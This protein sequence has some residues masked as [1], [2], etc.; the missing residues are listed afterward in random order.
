LAIA[1]A[2]I[3][4]LRRSFPM[5]AIPKLNVPRLSVAE[6]VAGFD[7]RCAL[8]LETTA[9]G[10]RVTGPEISGA[11]GDI[12]GNRAIANLALGRFRAESN[13]RL[14]TTA[15]WFDHPHP[16]DR[17]HKGE[18]DFAAMKLAR[19]YWLFRGGDGLEESTQDRIRRFFLTTEFMSHYHSE[20]HDLLFHTSRYLMAKSFWRET[21]EGYGK[22]GAEI[23]RE[24]ADWLL[25]FIR[26]RAQRGWAEFDSSCYFA[27]DWEC[28]CGLYDFCGS[29]GDLPA[30][31]PGEDGERDRELHLLAGM[32]MNLLLADM[33]VDSLN[34]LYGGAHGRIYEPHALDHTTASTYALQL[35]YFGCVDPGSLGGR[36]TLVDAVTSPFRP[37]ELVLEIAL[38]RPEVYE[39]RER[40][41][42]HSTED[43]RPVKPIPGSIR[44]YTYYTPEF[45]MGAVQRQDP[46]PEDSKA[47]WYAHHEQHEWDLSIGTRVAARIFTHHPGS[48]GPEHGY[49]TG[50]LRCCC[51]H[52]FQCRSVVLA[53]YDIPEDQAHQFIHA[54][55]RRSAFDEVIEEE[56][57]IFVREEGVFA[58][59][60]MMGGH[61]WPEGETRTERMANDE[62]EAFEVISRGAKNGAVCEAG[63]AGDYASFEA[64]R[65][66]ILGNEVAFDT[67]EMTLSYGSSQ[68]GTLSMDTGGNRKLNGEA[69]D[70]DY[71]TYDCPYMQSEWGSGT[72]QL[73][74]GEKRLVL[75]FST[76]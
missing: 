52:F 49:W 61:E 15:E 30:E 45:V 57:W 25:H 54:Y 31:A 59:L 55:V 56:G 20:N 28:M 47:R 35:L 44:K 62:G 64:F 74:K 73:R 18:C 66:E 43:V 8:L 41:H 27:P 17:H 58:A 10:S 32:M 7:A 36:G 6:S 60:R 71:A 40:K 46:Y 12:Y 11:K 9:G 53:L 16:N 14:R 69:V 37:D 33:A 42:L 67:E 50:D 75:D 19:A 24:D 70:L 4:V 39:N 38:D 5:S 48:D 68:V 26:Y 51:G 13:A 1:N 65:K 23:A 34:G 21:F 63:L 22:T 3:L 29:G 72:V 2:P 76:P